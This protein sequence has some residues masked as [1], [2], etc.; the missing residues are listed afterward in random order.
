MRAGLR[1]GVSSSQ[2]GA[3]MRAEPSQRLRHTSRSAPASPPLHGI[4][5]SVRAARFKKTA[6]PRPAPTSAA[7]SPPRPPSKDRGQEIAATPHGQSRS[8][9]EE[10]KDLPEE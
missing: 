7:A 9:V 2:G 4:S 1:T 6:G 5:P 3:R 8:V 10:G